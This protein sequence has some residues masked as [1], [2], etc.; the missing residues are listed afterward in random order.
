[1]SLDRLQAHM[2]IREILR[3][4]EDGVERDIALGINARDGV[5]EL[6]EVC[7]VDGVAAHRC[8]RRIKSAGWERGAF[9]LD[10]LQH[11]RRERR[12]WCF[13]MAAFARWCGRRIDAGRP[14][15]GAVLIDDDAAFLRERGGET[16]ASEKARD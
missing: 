3:R 15:V 8:D 6:G 7:G 16:G 5:G 10:A 2:A 13:D 1:M 4:H 9:H 12:G 14:A 11:E